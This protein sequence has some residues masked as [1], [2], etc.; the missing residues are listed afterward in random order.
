[1][2]TILDIEEPNPIVFTGDLVGSGS[3]PLQI[4]DDN[5]LKEYHNFFAPI[6]ERQIS[7][8]SVFGNHDDENISVS[9][10]KVSILHRMK[11]LC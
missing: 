11:E 8:A 5:P 4:S 7:W 2:E 6:I 9:R 1:M 3:I 10:K